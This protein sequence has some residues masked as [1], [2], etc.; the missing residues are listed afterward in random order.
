MLIFSDIHLKPIQL[1]E[2]SI[3]MFLAKHAGKDPIR[4]TN[5]ESFKLSTHIL[6]TLTS[7]RSLGCPLGPLL[8]RLDGIFKHSHVQDVLIGK[9]N[10]QSGVRLAALDGAVHGCERQHHEC[11]LVDKLLTPGAWGYGQPASLQELD[12]CLRKCG[13]LGKVLFG[14]SISIA[15]CDAFGLAEPSKCI[16]GQLT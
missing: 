1:M 16:E 5:H 10:H 13:I 8:A 11:F 3:T 7:F 14:R 12:V 4:L 15:H 2:R 9:S 6:Y